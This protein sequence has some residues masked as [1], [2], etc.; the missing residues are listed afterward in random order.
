MN[1][2]LRHLR[3][4]LAVAEELNFHRAAER[5]YVTQPALSR[6]IA[7][8]EHELG[9]QLFQRD[10]RRVELTPAGAALV[11]G[12]RDTLVRLEQSLANARWA[13]GATEHVL[14]VGYLPSCIHIVD[15]LLDAF[16]HRQ[17][18]LWLAKHPM[19][20]RAQAVALRERA[21]DVGFFYGP[22]DDELLTATPIEGMRLTVALPVD[23][24]LAD[25][26]PVPMQALASERLL[27]PNR[28]RWYPYWARVQA[29]F[30]AA[31][32]TPELV[33]L[34]ESQPFLLS[35]VLPKVAAG[36]G[37]CLL[38][39]P[40]WRLKY[41]EVVFQPVKLPTAAFDLAVV[42]RADA[43]SAEVKDFV[44]TALEARRAQLEPR[45]R[46]H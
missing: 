41:P 9:V 18:Q 27:L 4:F 3:Y 44:V 2:E 22:V 31:V 28:Q 5:L 30:Q 7:Q 6:Q 42:R 24:R 40:A 10:R 37:V 26:S 12:V 14:R 33:P 43:V 36:E 17:P 46:T 45:T 21:L 8:L 35:T 25:L 15:P 1:I 16:R 23:H 34:G 38:Q 32:I 13:Q 20:G 29:W 39:I 19:L 11:D